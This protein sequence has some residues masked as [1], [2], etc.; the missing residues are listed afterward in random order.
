M[1]KYFWVPHKHTSTY[2]RTRTLTYTGN[3]FIY[4]ISFGTTKPYLHSKRNSCVI[5]G[6]V[7]DLYSINRF[8]T[9]RKW[10]SWVSVDL[11]AYLEW[12]TNIPDMFGT[13]TFQFTI[14]RPGHILPYVC[15][16][17]LLRIITS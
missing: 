12:G 14:N 1:W 17:G 3:T 6:T 16:I 2:T 9:F 4:R 13:A 5:T 8:V 10:R 15:L 7:E 11:L